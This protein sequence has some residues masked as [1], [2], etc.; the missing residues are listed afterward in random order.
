[1]TSPQVRSSTLTVITGGARSGKSRQALERL[2]QHSQ[3]AFVATA[4]P[5]DEEMRS[6]IDAHRRERRDLLPEL[7]EIEAPIDLA[8]SLD[9][10]V[11]TKARIV[12]VDCLTVWLGN[13]HH[14]AGEATIE[15]LADLDHFAPIGAL[16]DRL[17]AGL[18]FEL[19]LVTNE[20]GLGL[21]PAEPRSR[22]F[23]DLAGRVNQAVAARA[24]ELVLMVSG[25]PFG[26]RWIESAGGWS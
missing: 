8:G 16:L 12:V 19:V 22:A 2:S 4:E 9:R 1:M 13:L 6:R 3:G 17:D 23:R 10:L 14:H 18:P 26:R 21:V 11:S 25:V 5:F 7:I 15:A 24:G 20:I